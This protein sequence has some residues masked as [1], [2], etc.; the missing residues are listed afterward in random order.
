MANIIRGKNQDT[1]T[2]TNVA[3]LGQ[4]GFG[5]KAAIAALQTQ[6]IKRSTPEQRAARKAERRANQTVEQREKASLRLQT[7]GRTVTGAVARTNRSNTS[8]AQSSSF[9]S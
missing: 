1:K 9:E 2:D 4:T 7:A 3:D 6:Q 5:A 8:A